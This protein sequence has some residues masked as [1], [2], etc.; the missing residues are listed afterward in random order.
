M[1]V[2][3]LLH[4]AQLGFR[5]LKLARHYSLQRGGMFI[6]PSCT[7]LKSKSLILT[8]EPAQGRI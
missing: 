7:G 2:L 3:H 4:D 8:L 5:S 1:I 6:S